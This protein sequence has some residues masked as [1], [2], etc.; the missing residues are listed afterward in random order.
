M[1][2]PLFYL[3]AILTQSINQSLSH[4]SFFELSYPFF[5]FYFHLG[6][7]SLYELE[8]HTIIP[9]KL[10]SEFL[11]SYEAGNEDDDDNELGGSDFI[12]PDSIVAVAAPPESMDSIWFVKVLEIDC[13]EEQ[14]M[15]G[16]YKNCIPK[17]MP[18]IKG[19]FLERDNVFK[20]HTTYT[21]AKDITFLIKENVLYPYVLMEPGKKGYTLQNK[22]YLDI[23]YHVK[24]TGFSH[25]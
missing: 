3:L 25:L 7:C 14:E 18:F 22:D 6:S 10:R 5:L 20:H 15:T 16:R 19:Q 11:P 2:H 8:S 23:L 4:L 21:L 17:C 9:P 13:V 12:V 24:Q 1:N